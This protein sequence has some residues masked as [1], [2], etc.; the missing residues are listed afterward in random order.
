MFRDQIRR[1]M[2]AI[3]RDP[4]RLAELMRDGVSMEV[5]DVEGPSQEVQK[6]EKRRKKGSRKH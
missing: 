1:E 5:T 6:R 2:D 4:K 3:M